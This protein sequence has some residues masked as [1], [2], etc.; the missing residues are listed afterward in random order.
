MKSKN[1]KLDKIFLPTILVIFLFSFN[2]TVMCQESSREIIVKDSVE[3]F[4]PIDQNPEFPGGMAELFK[5]LGKNIKYPADAVSEGITGRVHVKMIVNE[6][7]SLSD[8]QVIESLH[9]SL[10]K[11][12]IRVL[13][14]MP[15]WQP[16]Y[17]KGVAVKCNYTL[18]VK[19]SLDSKTL[20]KK[21]KKG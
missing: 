13:K 10:D 18:P 6:D 8:F 19:F 21:R 7:G 12:A 14:E 3:I 20:K 9:P 16:A 11:E 17:Q 1:Q 15:L 5:F 4:T 2:R